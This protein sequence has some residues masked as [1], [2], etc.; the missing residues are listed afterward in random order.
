MQHGFCFATNHRCK[1]QRM[2]KS[3]KEKGIGT[4]VAYRYSIKNNRGDL[5]VEISSG[6]T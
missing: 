4:V 5:D 2:C 6:S 1:M 3:S